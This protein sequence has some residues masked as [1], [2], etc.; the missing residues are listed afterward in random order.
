MGAAEA[1]LQRN[2]RVDQG[3]TP[4]NLTLERA[5]TGDD[6]KNFLH[7]N[8]GISFLCEEVAY[9]IVQK[10][11]I[12]TKAQIVNGGQTI[13]ALHRMSSSGQLK[14]DVLVPVRA[15]AA[16]RDK[17]EFGN[18]VTVNQNN[19]NQVSPDFLRSGDIRVVQLSHSLAALGWYLERRPRELQT[20]TSEEKAAIE[21]RIGRSLEGHVIKLKPGMQA[22]VATFYERLD[23]ARTDPG[24]I[25]KGPEQDGY[26]EN[27][28]SQSNGKKITAEKFIHSH[29]ILESVE[30][31]VSRFAAIKRKKNRVEDWRSLYSELL[32]ETIVNEFGDEIE[33]VVP[34]CVHFVAG[35]MYQ[36]VC[37]VQG[38]S[39]SELVDEIVGVDSRIKE[40]LL[41]IMRFAKDNPDLPIVRKAWL[42]R[43][44]SG[45][46]FNLFIVYLRKHRQMKTD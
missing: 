13:R 4:T 38:K 35:S 22:F 3:P 36:D 1:T 8:N 45:N 9:D 23:L 29:L 17:K 16:S 25:F 19:Q 14:P 39:P 34:Q 18:N 11:I 42:Y 20:A 40:H 31:F 41:L 24:R 43:L 26:F 12:L 30:N 37:K 28:F 21:V 7:Y 46:F 5:C 44:R 33:L 27:I 15:I 2:I 32:G 10:Q 6:S